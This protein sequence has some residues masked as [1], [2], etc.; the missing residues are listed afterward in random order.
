MFR[1][2][3]SVKRNSK[4]GAIHTGICNA[5]YSVRM[6]ND[7]MSTM[8]VSG[9]SGGSIGS[10]KSESH[11]FMETRTVADNK[12]EKSV[13]KLRILLVEDDA[14]DYV[15]IRHH[16]SKI[17][18]DRFSMDWISDYDEAMAAL[19]SGGCDLCLLDY[20]L[21]AYT[22]LELLA[23][24]GN[25]HWNTPIIFLTGQGEYE[26]DMQ[27]M[28]LG[29]A[30][31]L[32][33]DHLTASILERS[34]RYAMERETSRKALQEA[35]EDLEGRVQEKTADLAKANAELQRESEKVE[36]FAYSVS[37]DLKNPAISL[38]GL[39]KRLVEKYAGIF[40]EKGK[41]YCTHIM[42]SAEQIMT[43]TERINMFISSK[44]AP[45]NIEDL[46]FKEALAS[47]RDEFSE[48]FQLR[49]IRWSEPDHLPVIRVDRVSLERVFR[50]L[51]DNSLKYG[52]EGLKEIRID[53][54]ETELFWILSVSDD[55]IGINT[56]NSGK[57]FGLYK[58]IESGQ[59]TEGLGL[60][61]AIVKEIAEKHKG[62]VW[63]EPGPCRG[64]TISVSFSKGL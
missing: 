40:D 8:K 22:G 18:G 57:V 21:G 6:W 52:G 59:K 14:D 7:E 23:Q 12:T 41:T 34:I 45:M 29:A 10:E 35:Y 17:P 48:Q 3:S 56:E 36:L 62:E 46:D 2:C 27:A 47:I 31:Y 4:Q 33:K 32:V 42:K 61:L 38:Y 16:L 5:V 39:T 9:M 60:G 58:R 51:V 37:H 53:F 24:V 55:G 30:D 49:H 28:K 26:V 11:L 19:E 13:S 54:K 15:I 1:S 44:E 25:N 64:A 50:N 43:L 20:R 63:A